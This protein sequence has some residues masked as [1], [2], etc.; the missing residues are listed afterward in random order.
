M[1]D[2]DQLMTNFTYF[3]IMKCITF[4]GTVNFKQMYCVGIASYRFYV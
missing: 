3:D 4:G 2:K 1:S